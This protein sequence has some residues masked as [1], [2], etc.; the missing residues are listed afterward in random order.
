ML[1]QLRRFYPLWRF[2]YFTFVDNG[3]EITIVDLWIEPLMKINYNISIMHACTVEWWECN[4]VLVSGWYF[5][6]ATVSS[7]FCCRTNERRIR[8]VAS[9]A[10]VLLSIKLT[11]LCVIIHVRCMNPY[12]QPSH[13]IEISHLYVRVLLV[14]L[15][16]YWRS[17][18]LMFGRQYKC[19][20]PTCLISYWTW[21]EMKI[22]P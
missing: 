16:L 4:S 14:Y 17:G 6:V 10:W 5:D 18:E 19:L 11:K 15:Y 20:R 22:S 21:K 12:R 13:L 8:Y 1:R 3:L 9:A 2:L 7:R